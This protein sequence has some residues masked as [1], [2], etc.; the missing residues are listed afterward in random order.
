MRTLSLLKQGIVLGV[1][2]FSMSGCLKSSDP[3]FSIGVNQ[4]F[5]MQRGEGTSAQFIPYISIYSQAYQIKSASVSFDGDK[6]S[7]SRIGLFGNTMEISEGGIYGN[8]FPASSTIPNGA[9]AI[10]ATN[11]DATLTATNGFTIN[12]A[13]DRVMGAFNVTEFDYTSADGFSAKWDA[14]TNATA[15]GLVITPLVKNQDG[16]L[17]SMGKNLFYWDEGKDATKTSGKFNPRDLFQTGQ[18]MNVAVVAYS[19]KNNQMP[20]LL[21]QVGKTAYITWGTDYNTDGPVE[22]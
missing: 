14:V 19:S 12:I 13:T 16:T 1:L 18:E 15:Y 22:E 4:V 7:F 9:Y 6:Y 8:G 17:V 5:V 2:A 10:T 11:A 3:D 21:V 20:D